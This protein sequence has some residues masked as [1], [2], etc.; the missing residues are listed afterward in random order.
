MESIKG[1]ILKKLTDLQDP[2]KTY[3][4][5]QTYRTCKGTLQTYKKTP[6]HYK[7]YK[8][9]PTNYKRYKRTATNTHKFYGFINLLNV[10][11]L[12]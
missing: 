7:T 9:T 2:F 11:S 6:T 1:P 10:I 4:N 8:R 12:L 3:R 5:L